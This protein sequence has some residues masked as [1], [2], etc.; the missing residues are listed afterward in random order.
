MIA[1]EHWI[2]AQCH[3]LIAALLAG[4]LAG[5]FYQRYELWLKARP[6]RL[7]RRSCLLTDALFGLILTLFCC[8]WWFLLTDGDIRASVFVWIALGWLLWR[9]IASKNKG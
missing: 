1:P 4:L 2:A 9:K 7:Y 3:D 5:F 6:R 8:L